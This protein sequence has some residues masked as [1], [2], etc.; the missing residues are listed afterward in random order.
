[1]WHLYHLKSISK[2]ELRYQRF[3]QT[4][5]VFKFGQPNMA[6]HWADEYLKLSPY[7]THLIEGAIEVLLYLKEKY[8]LHLMTNGFKEIQYI[9]L[10]ASGV[11]AF[12]RHILISEEH[13][14]HKPDIRMFKLAESLSYAK[15]DECLMVGDNYDTDIVGALNANW[16]AIHLSSAHQETIPTTY[17]QIR[18]LSQL[19]ELL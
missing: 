17:L 10:E 2:E 9:K 12:F 1:M 19:K 16:Q 7:K 15:S 13:G 11:R 8:H 18:Q 6:Q 4:F 14:F 3:Y 5:Q